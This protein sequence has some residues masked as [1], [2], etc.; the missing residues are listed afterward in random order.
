[1]ANMPGF[2]EACRVINKYGLNG[3][4]GLHIVLTEG[5]PLTDK[6]KQ[7]RRFC[8]E[9]GVFRSN[10][11]EKRLFHLSADEKEAVGEEIRTQI[12]RCRKNGLKLTHVDSHH[13]IH[14]EKGVLKVIIP[15]MQEFGI[16]YIRIMCNLAESC[17]IIRRSYTVLYNN[18]LKHCGLSRTHYFGSIDQYIA[19]KKKHSQKNTT[20]KVFEIM[21]HPITNDN[22]AI[23]DMLNQRPMEQLIEEAGF[24]H[25]AE[26][27]SGA[28]YAALD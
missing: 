27:F 2:D 8:D 9:R 6:I 13:H 15:L 21:T 11:R 26:S 1:M 17:S 24:N 25:K 10:T 12:E 7:Q 3:H 4:V 18:Y 19:F 20:G 16:P 14:E 22:G 28:V 5:I 23:V